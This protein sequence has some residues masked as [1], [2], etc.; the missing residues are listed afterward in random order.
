MPGFS[1]LKRDMTFVYFRSGLVAALL[2]AS[3]PAMSVGQLDLPPYSTGYD[4]KRD[5][6]ADS[7]AALKLARDTDRKLLI[8]VGGDWCS[9]CHVLDRFLKENVRV[10]S[11]LHET[12]VLL[13]VNVSDANENASF[14]ATLPPAMGYPHMYIT[15]SSGVVLHS[16]NTAQL[17]ENNEYSEQQFMTF[18]D[19]WQS[20]SE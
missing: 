13:K 3:F 7:Q 20:Q 17:I 4:A 16:Q 2:L 6:Y 5:P 15:D 19:Y 9:W 1:S 11:R 10:A 8:E 18:L 14:M 12:F